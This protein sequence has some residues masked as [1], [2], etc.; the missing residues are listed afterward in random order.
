MTV[1]RSLYTP[2]KEVV[3]LI[4]IS[5]LASVILL[6][7]PEKA[8]ALNGSDFNPSRIIDDSVFYNNS[9]MTAAEIQSFLN[10]KVPICDTNGTKPYGGT[11]RA[12]YGTSRGYPPPY[13][14]LKDYQ[15]T[16][17]TVTNGGSDLC[18][19]S[20][21]GGTKSAAQILKDV[22]D[23]CG[24]NPQV[25]IVLLQKE[26]SL[27]TDDWPWSRQYDIA[28]GYACPDSG[29]NNSANCDSEYF[30]FFNQ[31]YNSAKAYR[32][33]EANPSYYNYRAGR[34][35][36][37]LYNPNTGCGGTN[38]FI[39]N[40]A[41]AS[42]YIYTPY[43]P[44]AA[45]LANLYGTGDG[46][47]AYGNRNFWRMFNDWFG[48]TTM[49]LIRTVD[50][51]TLY[52][53]D[54]NRKYPV[55]SMDLANQYGLGVEDVRY[56]NQQQVDQ[57]PTSVKPLSPVIKSDSDSDSD[58]SALYLIS[59]NR[60]YQF[61]SMSQFYAFGFTDSQITSM[62]INNII[63]LV[64]GGILSNFVQL[65]DL[66]VQK[67]EDNKKRAVF[68]LATL[69]T[70]NPSNAVSAVSNYSMSH[71]GIGEP[72][73]NG[74]AILKNFSGDMWLFQND[75]WL[76]VP[77]MNVYECWDFKSIKTFTFS[78]SQAVAKNNGSL[79]C[80]AQRSDGQKFIINKNNKIGNAENF[81][82]TSY[83]TPLDRTIDRFTTLNTNVNTP[84][85][86]TSDSSIFLLQNAKRRQ[87]LD[88]KTFFE[89]GY[90]E[91]Q[92]VSIDSGIINSISTT[93][94]LYSTGT[95]VKNNSDY[96]VVHENS[97]LPINS[98]E[99]FNNFGYSFSTNLLIS[100]VSTYYPFAGSLKT[101]SK[102]GDDHYLIDRK[103]KWFIDTNLQIHYGVT[104]STTNYNSLI[105]KHVSNTA[106]AT[107][108]IKSVD[109]T[110]VYFLE[111][112]T[113]RPISSWEKLKELNGQNSI[114]SLSSSSISLFPSGAQL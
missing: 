113:K 23:A 107:R 96:F 34:N 95:V 106:T 92:L 61:G 32:R 55:N 70:V 56:L 109:A 4:I 84:M 10:S 111:N 73:M 37:I 18:K 7:F 79:S 29:P 102:L 98:A 8:T 16:V 59:N 90:Q 54:T 65:P 13:T 89:L 88:M 101:I 53:T 100:S 5:L 75:K 81:G 31:I 6:S 108:F 76:K 72:L 48:I 74:D 43:Q 19:N 82:F 3:G 17:P 80:F 22:S 57:I 38:V 14:C 67:I 45:A 114:M 50:S 33:Y 36:F 85:K 35:N 58:G 40:Q 42:L 15:Q 11:T 60:R 28:M 39:E 47:S 63:R 99:I 105:A 83:S 2:T 66:F 77:S 1:T 104:S 87:I 52:Y 24:I 26:M 91:S 97:L 78:S 12:A 69:N 20:I 51:P 27:V 103:T 25:L 21:T 62:P 93:T 9:S 49:P 68:D 112:G 110:M 30:G 71:L 41:T 64:H 46:C 44:N 86:S 94:P